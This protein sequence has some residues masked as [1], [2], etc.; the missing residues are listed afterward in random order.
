MGSSEGIVRPEV[1]SS[2]SRKRAAEMLESPREAGLV[3]KQLLVATIVLIGVTLHAKDFWEKKDYSKWSDKELAKMMTKSPWAKTVSFVVGRGRPSGGGREPAGLP[4]SGEGGG[5]SGGGGRGGGGGGRSRTPGVGS[6][7]EF[8]P[9]VKL[10]VRWYSSLPIRQAMVRM[11]SNPEDSEAAT[12][13]IESEMPHYILWV[14]GFPQRMVTSADA[15][16]MDAMVKRLESE[17]FLIVKGIEP[18]PALD[19]QI[20]MNQAPQGQEEQAVADLFLIFP[21]GQTGTPVLALEHK[22]VEFL[23]KVGDQEIKKKFKLKDM[24]YNGRLEL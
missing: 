20:R 1:G 22:N 7:G 19:V 4:G 6:G 8:R 5:A 14:S 21:K 3:K 24:V 9:T 11:Y 13:S 12:Q 23:T 17:S 18:I 10:A 16:R 15:A 2:P